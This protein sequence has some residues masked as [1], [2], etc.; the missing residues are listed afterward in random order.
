MYHK[1]LRSQ[2][3][4]GIDLLRCAIIVQDIEDS[5]T[6]FSRIMN[7]AWPG[8]GLSQAIIFPTCT[9]I[10]QDL[11]EYKIWFPEMYHNY[12]PNFDFPR[13]KIWF[14]E[15]YH[16]YSRSPQFWFSKMYHNY[17]RSQR[18]KDIDFPRHTI[19]VQDLADSQ[20]R[21]SNMYIKISKIPR[22]WLL[23]M[24]MSCSGYRKI[25]A[26]L[27]PVAR[28]STIEDIMLWSKCV[29]A[30]KLKSQKALRVWGDP[31]GH[32]QYPQI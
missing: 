19:I 22:L 30:S 4:Q 6:W 28:P 26:W 14:A 24:Y 2:R 32:E 3:L 29:V 17:Q 13:S 18:F 23:R 21:F 25:I 12:L 8:Y 5:R 11:K 10:I 9:V 15:M 20:I 16:N 27:S 31:M 1:D 7:C